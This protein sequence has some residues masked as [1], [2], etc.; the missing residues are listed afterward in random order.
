VR[1]RR[2]VQPKERKEHT[3]FRSPSNQSRVYSQ[4]TAMPVG[5]IHFVAAMCSTYSLSLPHRP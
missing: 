2:H 3:A 1:T 4:H 5:N